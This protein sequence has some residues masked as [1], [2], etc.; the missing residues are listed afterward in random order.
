MEV[1]KKSLDAGKLQEFRW[2]SDKDSHQNRHLE[3]VSSKQ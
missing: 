3:M 1:T 2:L